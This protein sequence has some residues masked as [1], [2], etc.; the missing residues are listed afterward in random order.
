[1][2]NEPTYGLL[3]KSSCLAPALSVTK[4]IAINAMNLVTDMC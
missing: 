1:M 2:F 4:L 3:E